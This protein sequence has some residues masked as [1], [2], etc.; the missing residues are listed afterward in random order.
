MQRDQQNA[1]TIEQCFWTKIKDDMDQPERFSN[2][3]K[4]PK[5]AEPDL[6]HFNGLR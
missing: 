6:H 1:K 5:H 4:S 2:G 3:F